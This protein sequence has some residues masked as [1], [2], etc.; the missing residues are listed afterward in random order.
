MP[1]CGIV[2]S[3][4]VAVATGEKKIPEISRSSEKLLRHL[5]CHGISATPVEVA[6]NGPGDAGSALTDHG[7]ASDTD[8]LVMGA[9]G[10]GRA[11][12]CWA[13]RPK[14]GRVNEWQLVGSFKISLDDRN[15]GAKLPTEGADIPTFAGSESSLIAAGRSYGRPASQ[16]SREAGIFKF[17]SVRIASEHHRHLRRGI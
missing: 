16:R 10:P 12:S 9:D 11:S 17:R 1:F 13:A 2:G 7:I 8:L 4:E 5:G 15:Q 3:V 14:C 6:A